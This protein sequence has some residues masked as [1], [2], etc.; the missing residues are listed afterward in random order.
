MQY[1]GGQGKG[2]KARP[3]NWH[4]PFLMKVMALSKLA[5]R[6]QPRRIFAAPPK[7]RRFK[8]I[9]KGLSMCE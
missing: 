5:S 3:A 1:V 6:G 8:V 2:A 9:M 4:L 7:D